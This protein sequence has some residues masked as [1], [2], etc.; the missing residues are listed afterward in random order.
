MRLRES[1]A[2]LTLCPIQR[3]SIVDLADPRA[4]ATK[5]AP[6]PPSTILQ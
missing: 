4:D 5:G 1:A 2:V 3:T 6:V